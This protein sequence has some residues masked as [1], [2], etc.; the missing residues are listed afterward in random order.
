MNLNTMKDLTQVDPM[1]GLGEKLPRAEPAPPPLKRAP[2]P[3]NPRFKVGVDGKLE[4]NIPGNGAAKWAKAW[5]VSSCD[6][7][8]SLENFY[9]QTK[10]EFYAYLYGGRTVSAWI[11]DTTS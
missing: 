3:T 4:T 10:R 1:G 7:T 11:D 9:K 8:R 2:E 5:I 6:P